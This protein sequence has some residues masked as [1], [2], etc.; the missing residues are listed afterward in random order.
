MEEWSVGPK[1]AAS[2]ITMIVC[3]AAGALLGSLAL[4][5]LVAEA[6]SLAF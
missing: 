3:I 5:N 1:D 2:M 6:F 4:W